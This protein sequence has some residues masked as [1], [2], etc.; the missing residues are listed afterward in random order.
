MGRRAGVNK[1]ITAEIDLRPWAAYV[2]GHHPQLLINLEEEASYCRQYTAFIDALERFKDHIIQLDA[3]VGVLAAK[4]EINAAELNKYH[5]CVRAFCQSYLVMQVE[6]PGLFVDDV[7]VLPSVPG[8]PADGLIDAL[9]GL[10]A[11][12]ENLEEWRKLGQLIANYQEVHCGAS[13][14]YRGMSRLFTEIL[15]AVK[16][17]SVSENHTKLSCAL[18][19][20]RRD[21]GKRWPDGLDAQMRYANRGSLDIDQL[22][23]QIQYALKDEGPP[24]PVLVLDRERSTIFGQEI[25]MAGKHRQSIACLWVL[26]ENANHP[27]KRETIKREV[28]TDRALKDLRYVM[29]PLRKLLQ[30]LIESYYEQSKNTPLKHYDQQ[31]INGDRGGQGNRGG[32]DEH[33]PYTLMLP[34][35]LV[36]ITSARPIWMKP[37]VAPDQNPS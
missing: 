36:L 7:P 16:K 31:F 27:V 32:V 4:T 3:A 5:L 29:T 18:D 15:D 25:P 6:D 30:P 24:E 37:A 1:A 23:E 14:D 9:N 22:D 28:D 13:D 12:D 10:L 26:A 17:L 8:K 21:F 33:G 35:S 34:P 20:A 2:I 19:R 11:G